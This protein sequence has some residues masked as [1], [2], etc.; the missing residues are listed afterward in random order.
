[1]LRFWEWIDDLTIIANKY[2]FEGFILPVVKQV[3]AM[4][5]F[6]YMYTTHKTVSQ[7]K[8]AFVVSRTHISFLFQLFLL[9]FENK[10]I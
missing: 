6:M 10:V 9:F 7:Q 2:N 1:M 8:V 5:M 3:I 4:A